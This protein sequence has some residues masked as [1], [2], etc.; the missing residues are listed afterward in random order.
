[1]LPT[2]NFENRTLNGSGL[3]I[4]AIFESSYDKI[5]GGDWGTLVDTIVRWWDFFSVFAI[6]LSIIFFIGFIYAKLRFDQLVEIE[7]D[8]LLESEK[9][10]AHIYGDEIKKDSRWGGILNY[11]AGHNPGD[12]KVAIIEADILLEETLNKAGYVGVSIGDKLK[13]ANSSPFNS[14]EDA[15]E[16][17][18]I[19]NKIAH[20]GSDFIL[21]QKIAQDTI[22]RF[23]RIFRE[24]G[25]I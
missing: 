19:R 8:Q 25:T 4:F 15:W 20:A 3:D 14:L 6:I 12:W 1:M 22:N 10:W 24:F 23:E 7:S 18:K 21:T 9:A 2:V 16:A 11:V 5:G 17:H 13:S